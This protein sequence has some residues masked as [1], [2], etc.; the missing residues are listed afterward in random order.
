MWPLLPTCHDLYASVEADAV[1]KW[2]KGSIQNMKGSCSFSVYS[3]HFCA[4]IFLIPSPLLKFMPKFAQKTNGIR[5]M[6]LSEGSPQASIRYLHNV[7]VCDPWQS[8]LAS[9]NTVCA[10]Y[11]LKSRSSTAAVAALLCVLL[12]AGE[13]GDPACGTNPVS[14]VFKQTCC[15]FSSAAVPVWP[16]SL[17]IKSRTSW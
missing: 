11:Y 7:F 16:E 5:E 9:K 6:P 2:T 14:Q 8:L 1:G 4:V 17:W 15:Q 12:G 13:P 3:T 10:R